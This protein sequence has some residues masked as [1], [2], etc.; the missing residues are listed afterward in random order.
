MEKMIFWK[1]PAMIHAGEI[2]W[3][4]NSHNE[5]CINYF[6]Q[7]TQG[8]NSEILAMSLKKVP[9]KLETIIDCQSRTGLF[10]SDL[11]CLDCI[12]YCFSVE[13]SG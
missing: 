8:G 1:R 11:L 5:K 3:R 13:I 4:R 12:V 7:S 2:I 10:S 6:Y 9:S